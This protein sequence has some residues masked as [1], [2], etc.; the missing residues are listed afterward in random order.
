MVLVPA[1]AFLMGSD[2]ADAERKGAEFGSIKPWY[3]DE[4]P[5]HTL[6]LPAYYLDQYEVTNRQYRDFV[7]AVQVMPPEHW[8]TSGYLVSLKLDKLQGLDVEALRK[9]AA[10]LFR[11]DMDTRDMDKAQLL[12]AIEA[13]F[14]EMDTLPVVNVSWN[15]AAAYCQWAE[16]RLPSEAEWEKAA[17]GAQGSEFVWGDAWKEGVAN[18]GEVE[19]NWEF[20]VAPVGS[21]QQDKSTYGVYDLT[22]NVREWVA[23]WYQPY[24]GSDYQGKEFG[25]QYKVVRGAGE[26][27]GSGHYALSLFARAAYRGMLEP[28]GAYDDVGFRCA[29]DNPP[30]QR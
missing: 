2:K 18:V 6:E 15:D 24:P 19:E 29:K 10:K 16:K 12:G 21:Y 13:R 23:D 17:R 11:L 7:A 4:H 3:L 1:G 25:E 9:V 20:G 5:A 22:G 27:G 8:M 30:I 26:G 28:A 14:A